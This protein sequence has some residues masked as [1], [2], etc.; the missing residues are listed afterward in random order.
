MSKVVCFGEFMVGLNPPGY[1][2]FIQTDSFQVFYTGAE[3]NV[4]ASLAGF[5]VET[6]FV[7]RLPENA[8]G[9]AARANLRKYG[10]GTSFIATGGPRIGVIYTEKGASQ[11]PSS[12]IYDRANSSFALSPEESYDWDAIFADA[13][14]F[15]F[16]GIT[17]ALSD[18]LADICLIALKKAHEHGV[19]VSCDLNYRKKLWTTEKA[20]QVMRKLLPYVDVLIANE[21]DCEKVLGLKAGASDVT[22]GELDQSG[23]VS[24]AKQIYEQFG[25]HTV[26]TTLRKS[27][28]ASDND[29]S[30]MIWNDGEVY[31]SK[32]YSIR[33]VNRVG[34]G[35]SFSGG[36][37]YGLRKGLPMQEALEF[38][39]A[40]SCL[41]HTIEM[42]FNLVSVQ[43][44][45]ALKEGNGSGRVQR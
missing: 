38:A 3:A 6:E 17:P 1:M 11:R 21:E 40:A 13:D 4:A 43:E 45:E 33:I 35:D 34:G 5:G 30:A 14:W 25:I 27:Y 23:Y 31:L 8:I 24:V 19:K 16:T 10:I 2:R 9:D 18:N 26:A 12:V 22:K 42:D 28:S 36:L 32:T 29:W 15:H 7:T 20:G 39:T 37:I 44:V 41:K